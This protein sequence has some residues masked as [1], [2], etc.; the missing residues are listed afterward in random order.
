METETIHRR[1]RHDTSTMIIVGARKFTGAL[2]IAA[3]L[4]GLAVIGLAD[5]ATAGTPAPVTAT[6][7][8]NGRAVANSSGSNPIKLDPNHPA[9]VSV[10]VTNNGSGP[11]TVGAVA[12]SG[13][14]LDIPFFDFETETALP[15]Q[16]GTTETQQYTLDFAPLNN[17]GDG[18]IP[19]S[20][21][22]LDDHRHVLAGQNFTAD[23]RGR[24]TS[25]FGLF[26]IEVLA[27]TIILFA[28]ALIAMAR[29]TLHENRF[30]RALRFLWP[31][32]GLGIL[33]VFGFAILRI[34]TPAPGHWLPIVLVCAA[35]GFAVGYLTPNPARDAFGPAPDPE[36]ASTD[37][38]ATLT[39]AGVPAAR[40]PLSGQ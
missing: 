40:S 33:I 22:I 23:V 26:A 37:P 6:F 19:A 14:A 11:V 4:F 24:I 18:L 39:P 9:Q 35:I 16:P 36:V 34:F 1:P 29:G 31:G 20:I 30:R 28:G 15:V 12:L 5:V 27:F 25:L 21:H 17:Q 32:V 38:R 13:R 7:T 3:L 10:Q 8:V 2:F